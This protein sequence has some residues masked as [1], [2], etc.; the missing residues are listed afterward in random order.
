MIFLE[1]V[2]KSNDS[3]LRSSE[4]GIDTSNWANDKVMLNISQELGDEYW[5]SYIKWKKDALDLGELVGL[6]RVEYEQLIDHEDLDTIDKYL[7]IVQDKVDDLIKNGNESGESAELINLKGRILDLRENVGVAYKQFVEKVF[8]L[9]DKFRGI[10]DESDIRDQLV[11][12]EK[13]LRQARTNQ[14]S[15]K[16]VLELLKNTVK[17]DVD[18][19]KMEKQDDSMVSVFTCASF[20]DL[21]KSLKLL[22]Y[23][24]LPKKNGNIVDEKTYSKI[25]EKIKNA[26]GRLLKLAVALPNY[27]FEI[28]SKNELVNTD[29]E[30]PPELVWA[31]NLIYSD[32]FAK[33]MV[34]YAPLMYERKYQIGDM[35][36]EK[37]EEYGDGR[38]HGTYTDE[39]GKEL[40][41]PSENVVRDSIKKSFYQFLME[42]DDTSL[43][44]HFRNR[45]DA[46][47][48]K[49]LVDTNK[50]KNTDVYKLDDSGDEVDRLLKLLKA[51]KLGKYIP[52]KFD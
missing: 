32:Q 14:D 22:L 42:G 36:H 7:D 48:R 27:G 38:L 25:L 52:I 45:S 3:E 51:H 29:I 10:V 35:M 49:Y 28:T 17:P 30:Y 1:I 16:V 20:D 47:H 41:N 31:S 44:L 2:N 37:W 11:N 46:M 9:V 15:T 50:V 39:L 13:R 24:G 40:N 26:G 33:F 4:S 21:Q 34:V 12:F 19:A 23:K 8:V 6:D 43:K 18:V 5:E